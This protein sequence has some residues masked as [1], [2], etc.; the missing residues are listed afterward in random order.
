VRVFFYFLLDALAFGQAKRRKKT[1]IQPSPA[2]GRRLKK[3]THAY[4]PA[5]E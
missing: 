4:K 2:S 3:M 1:L 5:L